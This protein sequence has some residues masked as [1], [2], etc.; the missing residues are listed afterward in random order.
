MVGFWARLWL[1][2]SFFGWKDIRSCDIEVRYFS[3]YAGNAILGDAPWMDAQGCI[4]QAGRWPMIFLGLKN[5]M[6]TDPRAALLVCP[7]ARAQ[8]EK[9]VVDYLKERS[10]IEL[11][12]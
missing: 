2:V 10:F 11:M 1:H 6:V 5:M 7:R 12:I 9:R 8:D 4:M 3:M